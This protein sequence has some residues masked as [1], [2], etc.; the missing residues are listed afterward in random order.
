M[1]RAEAMATEAKALF[2]NRVYIDAA[3]LFME[4][5]AISRRAP[6]VYNAARAYEEGGQLKRAESLFLLYLSL[7]DADEAGKGDASQHL[8]AV[9]DRLAVAEP[10]SAPKPPPIQP[11]PAAPV[12]VA[13]P[14]RPRWPWVAAGVAVV[15]A[16][17]LYAVARSQAGSLDLA[18]V[19]DNASKMDYATRRDQ[20]STLRWGAVGCAAVAGGLAAYGVVSLLRT[21]TTTAQVVPNF[22][23]APGLGVAPGQGMAPSLG[24]VGWF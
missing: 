12:V 7:P 17:A 16:G 8:Q 11:P 6:L 14:S 3:R 22:G 15:G 10:S 1:R 5:F 4:A 13:P 2:Q 19:V 9:R 24:I 21:P 18:D 20:A 23:L